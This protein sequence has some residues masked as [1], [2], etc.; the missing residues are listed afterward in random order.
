MCFPEGAVARCHEGLAARP[1]DALLHG[2]A[3]HLGLSGG[4][5]GDSAGTGGPLLFE[6]KFQGTKSSYEWIGIT[7]CGSAW[8]PCWRPS[9]EV[10]KA[11]RQCS[12][13]RS[14]KDK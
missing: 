5:E 4:E 6:C 13:E 7:Q 2:E 10:H 14:L 3:L 12:A 8:T 1:E 11:D 9:L